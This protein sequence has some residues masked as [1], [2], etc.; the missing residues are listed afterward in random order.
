MKIIE[1]DLNYI[2]DE[3]SV[4]ALGNFDGVHK[5]HMELI[6]RAVKNAKKLN[7]KS[8]LLLFNE[9]TD[10]LVKV[11]KKDIIQLTKQN[12]KLLKV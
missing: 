11:G 5:G 4:I 12:L 10:N 2:A 6:N 3:D 9:H 8:S 1:I 7:I